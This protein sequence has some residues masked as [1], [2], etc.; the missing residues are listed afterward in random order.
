MARRLKVFVTSD[1]LTDY[2]VAATSKAKA[3]AA[4]GLR[5]DVFKEG[6]AGETDDAALVKAA[7][8]RPGEV[9][10]RA[11]GTRGKLERLTLARPAK[12]K[13][14]TPAQ[15]E[16]VAELETQLSRL[17]AEREAELGRIAK[18]QADLAKQRTALEAKMTA[19]RARLEAR[20]SSAR[21]ALE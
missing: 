13:S 15:R 6:R 1:G 18:A 12:A 10:R 8:A 16:R 2:I 20:L 5:Q 17:D 14:P 3:L 7:T 4:W 19:Q 21:A 9:L 11:A